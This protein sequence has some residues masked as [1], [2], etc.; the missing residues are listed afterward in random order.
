M[1]ATATV[2]AMSL[3]VVLIGLTLRDVFDAL[4]HHGGK[5]ML[6]R[7]IMRTT[8]WVFHRLAHMRAQAF[9][10]AG[11]V[12][13]LVVVGTWAALLALG[14]AFILWPHMSTGVLYANGSPPGRAG[15]FLDALYLSLVTLGTIGFGDITPTAGWLKIVT[16][17]EALLG[18]GLLTVS[19]SWLLSI[20]PALLRRRSLAY[21]ISLLRKAEHETGTRVDRLDAEAGGHLYAELTSRLVAVERD[22]VAFPVSY[23]FAEPDERFSLAA[24]MPYLLNLAERGASDSTPP[25]VRLRAVMLRG[26]I[27]DFALTTAELFHGRQSP[28]AATAVLDAYAR[29]HLQKPLPSSPQ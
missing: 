6:S 27:E 25:S 23:Y 22:F 21:E 13:L 20:Y 2:L 29:D 17:I 19:V 8:W 10:L 26:A 16:P 14:W 3:G 4:F 24:T 5:A 11:P 15:G 28:S 12:A 18:F 7:A 9:A 1:S